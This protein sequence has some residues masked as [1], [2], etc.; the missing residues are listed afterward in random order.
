VEPLIQTYQPPGAAADPAGQVTALY[1][2]HALGLLRLAVIMLG[3]RQ[4][5]EDV[6]QDAFLGLY[7]RYGTLRNPDRAQAYVRSAV[8]NGCRSVLRKRARDRQFVLADPEA[9]SAEA[10]VLLSEE[11]AEVLAAM[12]RLP[13][14]QREAVA[15]RYCLDMSLEDAARVMGVS[16]GTVKSATSRGIAALGR[17]LEA[18]TR[19]ENS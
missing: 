18:R 15:L 17:M 5:A 11:H 12:R 9:E 10:S 4:A 7:R 19:E 16:Q 2:A 3:D 13:G 1:Q 6:V 14:R 8:F